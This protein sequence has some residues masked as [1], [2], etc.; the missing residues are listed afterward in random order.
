ME[1]SEVDDGYIEGENCVEEG[2]RCLVTNL[3]VTVELERDDDQG[4][5]Y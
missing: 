3:L 2:T 1:A 4:Y 5:I